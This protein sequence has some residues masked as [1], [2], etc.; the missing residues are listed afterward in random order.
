MLIRVRYPNGT[1]DMVKEQTLDCLLEEG[2][3]AGFKR[4]EGWAIVGRDP[5]RYRSAQDNWHHDR[6]ERRG[7]VKI[8]RNFV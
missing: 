5:I 6:Q 1:Y 3:I 2:K 8:S 4:T 7:M